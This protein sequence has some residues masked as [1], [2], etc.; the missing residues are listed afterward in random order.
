MTKDDKKKI[1]DAYQGYSSVAT[2]CSNVLYNL[3]QARP[4]TDESRLYGKLVREHD[5]ARNSLR[6]TLTR[7]GLIAEKGKL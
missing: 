6:E 4:S 3:S 5:A 1:A 7:F 2:Q